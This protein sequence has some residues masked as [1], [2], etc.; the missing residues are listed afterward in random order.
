MSKDTEFERNAMI[1]VSFD[2]QFYFYNM[3]YGETM[4]AFVDRIIDDINEKS[5]ANLKKPIKIMRK[6]NVKLNQQVWIIEP[7][8]G[9]NR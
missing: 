2:D 1:V 4:D 9:N 3:L 8:E 6:F 7:I 5:G